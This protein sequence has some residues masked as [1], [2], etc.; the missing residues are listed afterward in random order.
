MYI[1]KPS[2]KSPTWS[3][4]ARRMSMNAPFTASTW[5]DSTSGAR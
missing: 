3:S 5:P 1:Q 4:A 2:S